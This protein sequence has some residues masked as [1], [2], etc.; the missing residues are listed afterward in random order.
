KAVEEFRRICEDYLALEALADA[1]RAAYRYPEEYSLA[2]RN[3]QAAAEEIATLERSRL[4]LGQG[5]LGSLPEVLEG[6]AGL[7]VFAIPLDEFR[8]AGMF[9]Y[10]ERLG[11]CILVN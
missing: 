5:P 1:P 11:G 7:R 10:T 9:A 3:P 6:D 4:H 2:G 8:I